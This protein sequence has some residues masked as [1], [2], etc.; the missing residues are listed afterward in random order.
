LKIGNIAF[1]KTLLIA[2]RRKT[3]LYQKGEPVQGLFRGS[4]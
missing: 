2:K 1:A 4:F 3:I